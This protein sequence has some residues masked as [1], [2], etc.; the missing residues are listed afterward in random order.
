MAKKMLN[1]VMDFLGLEEEI[2]EIEEMDNEA[3]NEENGE[4][5]NIFDASNVR[6]QKGKVVSIHTA[7][8]TKVIILKPMDYDAAIEICDNLKARKIIVV[9]MTSLESKIAQRLLDFIAG[10]SYALGGSLD[11]IYKGVYI[12]SPSNVE[13]TNE[14]KNE[15][16]SK[17][18]LNWTK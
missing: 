2:D 10:A 18:I 9:N 8:S 1:K 12:I 14:L 16:S 4:I 13:I 17:G 3:L 11:E 6:N 15:L 5:E 7:A